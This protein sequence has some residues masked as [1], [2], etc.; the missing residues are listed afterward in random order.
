MRVIGIDPGK[1]GAIAVIED[2][3]DVMT[4]PKI[5]K[6]L[7]VK[8]LSDKL[9]ELIDDKT[10]VVTEDVHSLYGVGA[11]STFSFGWSV[12]LIE[13]ILTALRVS[14]FKV[15]PK[16]WQKEMWQG[17]SPIYKPSKPEQKRKI[18]DTKAT[19]LVAAQRLFPRVDMRPTERSKKPHDGIVDALLLAEYGRRKY[20]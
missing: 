6:E 10:L 3:I 13:G 9:T 1:D 17:V 5:G 15:Q 2:S 18:V 19:S 7:D 16:A 14:F 20:Q 4:F 11:G 12:G 8:G